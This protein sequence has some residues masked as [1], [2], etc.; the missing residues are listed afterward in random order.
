MNQENLPDISIP[1]PTQNHVEQL[2]DFLTENQIALMIGAGFS[3][4]A[5]NPGNIP[6]PDWAAFKNALEQALGYKKEQTKTPIVLAQEYLSYFGEER[7]SDFIREHVPDKQLVPSDIYHHLLD[8]PWTDVFTTNY[9]TLLERTEASRLYSLVDEQSK[10]SLPAPRIIKLHG[11]FPDKKPFIMAETHYQD[12]EKTHSVFC[13]TIR[14]TM[15]EKALCLI[16]FSGDDPNFKY[17][18]AWIRNNVKNK[19][20][21]FLVDCKSFSGAESSYLADQNI[22]LINLQDIYIN[23]SSYQEKLNAFIEQLRNHICSKDEEFYWRLRWPTESH[24]NENE[25]Q[26]IATI[27]KETRERYPNW[28]IVPFYNRVRLWENTER[29]FS[30]F[31]AQF[32]L[33]SSVDKLQLLFEFAWRFEKSLMPI[34]LDEAYRKLSHW[35][36][37]NLLLEKDDDSEIQLQKITIALFFIKQARIRQE[38]DFFDFL[39]EKFLAPEIRNNDAKLNA[40]YYYEICLW[41]LMTFDLEKLKHLLEDW[42][43]HEGYRCDVLWKANLFMELNEKE[44]ALSLLESILPQLDKIIRPSDDFAEKDFETYLLAQISLIK[45]A[46]TFYSAKDAYHANKVE[47]EKWSQ[48]SQKR[49]HDITGYYGSDSHKETSLYESHLKQYPA[50]M[51]E[52]IVKRDLLTGQIRTTKNFRYV[53]KTGHVAAFSFPLYCEQSGLSASLLK[54]RLYD[55]ET[56]SYSAQL[57]FYQSMPDYSLHIISRLGGEGK[58]FVDECFAR[59]KIVDYHLEFANDIVQQYSKYLIPLIKTAVETKDFSESNFAYKACKVIP[60]AIGQCSTLYTV[61]ATS[62]ALELAKA[63]YRY[64]SVIHNCFS[65]ETDFLFQALAYG[66]D[67]DYLEKIVPELLDLWVPSPVPLGATDPI[68]FV[69]LIYNKDVSERKRVQQRISAQVTI[70]I[71][72]IKTSDGSS[73]IKRVMH[74]NLLKLIAPEQQALFRDTLWPEASSIPKI[75][76]TAQLFTLPLDKEREKVLEEFVFSLPPPYKDEKLSAVGTIA[77]SISLTYGNNIPFFEEMFFAVDSCQKY[78][79]NEVAQKILSTVRIWWQEESSYLKPCQ[80]EDNFCPTQEDE[81]WKRFSKLSC[82]SYDII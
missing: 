52:N 24:I 5:L 12:Y 29:A 62:Q 69:T 45:Q 58:K 43:K 48:Y 42:C 39:T 44:T 76:L 27:F 49:S 47:K 67:W 9:D 20:P 61:T 46:N 70:A 55:I 37:K 23:Q 35:V 78:P 21:I 54:I 59:S 28:F 71:A 66:R 8:L 56:T 63:F 26:N 41:A 79:T 72:N 13:H 17:W 14:Q 2:C 75:R 32:D 34:Y 31:I 53:L 7:Y 30:S 19:L 81:M 3:K 51:S 1:S 6:I 15:T 80:D 40:N 33:L 36:K 68:L 4:N 18:V 64:S 16:G 60:Y 82:R 50:G 11:S 22:Y 25:L 73:W 10:I 77:N 57:Y 74:L 38:K 65:D